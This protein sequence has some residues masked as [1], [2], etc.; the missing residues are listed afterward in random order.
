M[1]APTIDLP[2]PG[3]LLVRPPDVTNEK[4][5][6]NTCAVLEGHQHDPSGISELGD[7]IVALGQLYPTL[8][9]EYPDGRRLIAAGRRR[10]MACK[11]R[12]LELLVNI[13]YCSDEEDVNLELFAK[14][15]RIA[16]NAERCDPSA[17][18]IAIQLRAIRSDRGF[19][20]SRDLGLAIGMGESR[21]KKYLSIF[22][23]SD[24]LQ[25]KAR[26]HALPIEAMCELLKFEK[27]HGES[28]MKRQLTR[29]LNKEITAAD[30]AKLR[31]KAR[32]SR[33]K[34]P[35]DPLHSLRKSGDTL[36]TACRSDLEQ[37][38]KYVS[39]LVQEL[40]AL[41]DS[42]GQEEAS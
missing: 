6:P 39:A 1:Q 28:K 9:L 10:W 15:V 35:R 12:G 8:L 33:A 18:D 29:Y 5:D 41:L 30:L 25:Q 20:N 13:W 3:Q 4:I 34:A 11:E 26:E 7:S 37:S 14:A 31:G 38:H 21:V 36:L 40:Q 22:K 32:K 19:K 16:E 27:A 24:Y 23:A 2:T 42:P 17:M